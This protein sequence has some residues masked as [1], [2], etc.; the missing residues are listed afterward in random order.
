M[1]KKTH[2]S[3]FGSIKISKSPFAKKLNMPSKS[4]DQ[5]FG[6]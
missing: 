4:F 6:T 5:V 3:P 2:K 1:S